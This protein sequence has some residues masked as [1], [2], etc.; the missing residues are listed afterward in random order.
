MGQVTKED[1]DRCQCERER[2]PTS[3]IQMSPSHTAVIINIKY[4]YTVRCAARTGTVLYRFTALHI[5]F[6][7]FL[8]EVY[9]GIPLFQQLQL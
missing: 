3:R 6:A 8:D 7:A 2:S 5:R 4:L 1:T 9:S